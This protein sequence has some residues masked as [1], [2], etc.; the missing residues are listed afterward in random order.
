LYNRS[1][2]STTDLKDIKNNGTMYDI[3]YLLNTLVPYKM[4]S[5]LRKKW[6]SDIGYLHSFPIELHLGKGL[7]YLGIISSFSV[8]HKIFNEDMVPLMSWVNITVS[9]M[10][11]VAYEKSQIT[12]NQ[13][14]GV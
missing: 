3:E 2:V 9:R 5:V 14:A 7:R 6:T 4:K 10:P 8:Q 13:N 11:D 12:W 1:N